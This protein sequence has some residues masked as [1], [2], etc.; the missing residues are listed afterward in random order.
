MTTVFG[1]NGIKTGQTIA[2]SSNPKVD[3]LLAS[4]R[5]EMNPQKREKMYQEIQEILREDVPIIVTQI[6]EDLTI[7]GKNITGLWVGSGGGAVFNDVV[8]K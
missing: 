5:I 4:A 3:S 2:S 6:G 8:F 7:T 1:T